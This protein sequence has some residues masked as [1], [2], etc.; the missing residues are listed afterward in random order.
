MGD[1]RSGC[2]NQIKLIQILS[3][4]MEINKRKGVRYNLTLSC[5][6]R[7][8]RTSYAPFKVKVLKEHE[9]KSYT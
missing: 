1:E 5:S 3:T 9:R 7:Y 8:I 6:H 4:K 2:F